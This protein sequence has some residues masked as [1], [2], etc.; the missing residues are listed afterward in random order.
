MKHFYIGSLIVQ[1]IVTTNYRDGLIK[2]TIFGWGG[3]YLKIEIRFLEEYE[4]SLR[5][6][7]F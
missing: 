5:C 1:I 6:H 3:V 2:L 4:L 7:T